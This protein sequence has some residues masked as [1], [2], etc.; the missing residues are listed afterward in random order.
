L[1]N[2]GADVVLTYLNSKDAAEAVCCLAGELGVRCGAYQADAGSAE[3]VQRMVSTV[4]AEYG[5]IDVLVNNAGITRDKSFVKMSQA[6]WE[7]VLMTNLGGLFNT[8]QAVLPRM[9]ASGWGRIINVSSIVGLTGNFGQANYAASKAGAIALT[10]TL[11]R[12]LG[13]KG[14]T[15]NAVA[16]GFVETDMTKDLPAVVVEQVKASTPLARFGRPEEVA[17]VIAFLASP[18]ASYITGQVISVNGGLYMAADWSY[19]VTGLGLPG[20]NHVPSHE[21]LTGLFF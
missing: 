11:A 6:M 4:L 1:A 7:Q 5:S 16:P 17:D 3:Q 15:V 20:L 10:M 2:S 14:I 21:E 9:I 18:R 8:T 13:R 12:E 19:A